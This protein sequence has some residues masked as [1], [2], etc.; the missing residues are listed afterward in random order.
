MFLRFSKLKSKI[1]GIYR[2]YPIGNNGTRQS[3]IFAL[4]LIWFVT[5]NCCRQTR[6]HNLWAH[7]IFSYFNFMSVSWKHKKTSLSRQK[8]DGENMVEIIISL[9]D[10]FFIGLFWWIGEAIDLKISWFLVAETLLQNSCIFFL[11]FCVEIFKIFSAK[12]C[13]LHLLFLTYSFNS[14]SRHCIYYKNYKFWPSK[15]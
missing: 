9:F 8:V 3:V 2:D 10:H 14:F 4:P 15:N 1:P 7:R 13:Y 12:K 6:I 5:F 11:G